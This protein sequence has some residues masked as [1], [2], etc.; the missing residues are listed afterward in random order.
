LLNFFRSIG[1]G[2][3]ELEKILYSWNEKNNPKLQEGYI[4]SQI[5]YALKRKPILPPNCMEFYQGIASCFP[6]ELCR[7]IKNPVNYIVKKNF[8]SNNYKKRGLAQ[9]KGQS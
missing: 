4:K 7:L 1:T 6:D 5:S 9:K 2:K 8:Q 3:E